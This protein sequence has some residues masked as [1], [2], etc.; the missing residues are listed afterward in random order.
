MN[1]ETPQ[2]GKRQRHTASCRRA[3]RP[4][5]VEEHGTPPPRDTRAPVVVDLDDKVVEVI[6][7]PQPIARLPDRAAEGAVVVA[8]GGIFAPGQIG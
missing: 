7:A 3:I 4:R 5:E 8:V 1:Y 6:L 2:I